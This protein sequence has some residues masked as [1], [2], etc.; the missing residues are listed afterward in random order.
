MRNKMKIPLTNIILLF[1]F[2]FCILNCKEKN[3][4]V[5]EVTAEY[6]EGTDVLDEG[7]GIEYAHYVDGKKIL[8]VQEG[9]SLLKDPK[10]VKTKEAGMYFQLES[11]ASSKTEIFA[12]KLSRFP[13]VSVEGKVAKVRYVSACG[14][15]NCE[16]I[17]A[18]VYS[19]DLGDCKDLANSILK[20]LDG[21]NSGNGLANFL[22]GFKIYDNILRPNGN[23]N[24]YYDSEYLVKEGIPFSD[25]PK[26]KSF[27][28]KAT[29][30][31]LV[32]DRVTARINREK[33][34]PEQGKECDEKDSYSAIHSGGKTEGI[35]CSYDIFQKISCEVS[36]IS[37]SQDKKK[38]EFKAKLLSSS[39]KMNGDVCSYSIDLEGYPPFP[40]GY[41]TTEYQE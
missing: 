38:L 40:I 23:S 7:P 9:N 20:E 10:C 8:I 31:S 37:L 39:P 30:S 41:I 15:Y 1:F 34:S 28:W 22:I 17:E 26:I 19:K 18:F 35:L 32:L 27:Q 33:Y 11:M 25:D 21:L 5:T 2:F 4:A 13:W 24:L 14:D 16:Y 29:Q 12:S 36:G 3:T 6:D